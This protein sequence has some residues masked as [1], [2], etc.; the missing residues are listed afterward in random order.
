MYRFAKVD[1][2][3]GGQQ[4]PAGSPVIA[5]IGSANHDPSQFPEPE[6][7][8]IARTPNRHVAFGFGIHYCLGAPLAR[9]EA[10][11]ALGAMLQRF[12][13]VARVPESKLE[14]LPSL[15]V[16]GLKSIPITFTLV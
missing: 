8:D 1:A 11:I 7:F 15:I 6:K 16:Y 9:L 13:T 14:R 10:R 12:S 3:V 4:I 2:E 5:W